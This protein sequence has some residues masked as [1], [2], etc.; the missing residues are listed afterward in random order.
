LQYALD[1]CATADPFERQD[2]LDAAVVEA[3]AWLAW[4][5]GAVVCL[6]CAQAIE[7]Q[8]ARSPAEV[9]QQREEM[10][11]Q[12]ELANTVLWESGKCEHWFRNCDPIIQKVSEGVNGYLLQEL[13]TASHHCDVAAVELFRTGRLVARVVCRVC[14]GLCRAVLCRCS[15][16][17][18]TGTQRRGCTRVR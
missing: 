10:I 15:H 17:G 18:R 4:A 16:A 13:L 9:M 7:W 5:G 14:K 2:Q 8:A 12:I 11:S 1:M 3:R 6:R